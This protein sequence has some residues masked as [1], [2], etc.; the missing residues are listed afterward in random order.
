MANP[1]MRAN[2]E[3]PL[4][5]ITLR[6]AQ[7]WGREWGVCE[8]RHGAGLPACS[9]QGRVDL[10]DLAAN[11]PGGKKPFTQGWR[12]R[13]GEAHCPYGAAATD[14]GAIAS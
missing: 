12:L 7:P 13:A 3:G 5:V 9:R 2:R 8:H 4:Q 10:P 14:K 6:A 1:N 11:H